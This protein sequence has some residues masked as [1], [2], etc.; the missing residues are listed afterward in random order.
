MQKR[1]NV[2]FCPRQG[3]QHAEEQEQSMQGAGGSIGNVSE[4]LRAGSPPADRQ[5]AARA[6]RVQAGFV[7]DGHIRVSAISV[8]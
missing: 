4:K 2:P 7:D 8:G 3:H 6:E 5:Q 1:Q